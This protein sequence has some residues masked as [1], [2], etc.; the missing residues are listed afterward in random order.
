LPTPIR[1]LDHVAFLVADTET[2]LTTFRDRFGLVV[3]A[4]EVNDEAHVRMTYLDAGNA[5]LQLVEPLSDESPLARV[6]RNQGEGLHHI[7]FAVDDVEAAAKRFVAD[8][9]PFTWGAGGRGRRSAF[10]P[11]VPPHGVTVELNEFEPST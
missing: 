4:Q 10:V 5:L 6:L 7:C 3:V 11:G 1:S 9:T 8:E 2:A